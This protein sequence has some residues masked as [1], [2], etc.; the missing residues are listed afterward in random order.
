MISGLTTYEVIKLAGKLL[1]PTFP[2][3]CTSAIT[4]GMSPDTPFEHF[5][6]VWDL[7][8]SYSCRLPL[9]VCPIY[10]HF[11]VGFTAVHRETRSLRI[12]PWAVHS[13]Y[14][15]KFSKTQGPSSHIRGLP[16]LQ[17]ILERIHRS[18]K[19][20]LPKGSQALRCGP[21]CARK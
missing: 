1:Q 9:Y 20:K 4:L 5:L 14:M 16:Y 3:L 10:R 13:R 8:A 15:S 21:V 11:R 12:L 7:C 17:S 19:A 2:H 18:A 6:W